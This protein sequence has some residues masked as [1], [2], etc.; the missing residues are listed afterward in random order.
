MDPQ[1]DDHPTIKLIHQRKYERTY[2]SYDLVRNL[3]FGLKKKKRGLS[4]LFN[5]ERDRGTE[6]LNF[7]LK[8]LFLSQYLKV[9]YF[10]PL[11]LCKS[12]F[13]LLLGIGS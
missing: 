4:S 9:S 7:L 12:E 5:L 6:T 8:Q 10:D 2:Y 1:E 13:S 3:W 11:T